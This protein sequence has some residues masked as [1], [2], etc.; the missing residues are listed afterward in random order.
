MGGDVHGVTL[1][2][3]GNETVELS[4]AA[5]AIYG[6]FH[7]FAWALAIGWVIFACC[8][9][10][11]GWINDF[12]SWEFF[13]PL[14]KLTYIMY[15]VHLTVNQLIFASYNT[16]LMTSSNFLGVIYTCASLVYSL[17]TAMVIYI[18]FELPWLSTEKLI[19][20][21]LVGGAP[22][23]ATKANPADTKEATSKA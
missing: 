6:G 19:V 3:I 5:N 2:D 8:R 11:G 16:F 17:A 9:G 4:L 20:S 7:R 23:K 10:Y 21:L 22:P 18:G 13:Q 1:P 14:S 15:L 12:L